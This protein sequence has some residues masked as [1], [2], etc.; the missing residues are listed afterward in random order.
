[1]V[2]PE[3]RENSNYTE[4]LEAASN[5]V[6]LLYLGDLTMDVPVLK[7]SP[8]RDMAWKE[9]AANFPQFK[10]KIID[11]HNALKIS[12][13]LEISCSKIKIAERD[14]AFLNV[15]LDAA[16][17]LTRILLVRTMDESGNLD[18]TKDYMEEAREMI[19]ETLKV[20]RGGKTDEIGLVI[21][22]EAVLFGSLK[23]SK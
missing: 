4:G 21:V 12:Y 14:K 8:E 6:G 22:I 10:E 15:S 3:K 23:L 11:L 9:V 16:S 7:L 19:D 18:E 2:L 5:D 17:L 13:E 20:C 1:M